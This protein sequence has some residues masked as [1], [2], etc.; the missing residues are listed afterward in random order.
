MEN[1]QNIHLVAFIDILG[2]RNI[3]G[4]YFNGKNPQALTNLTNALEQAQ[5]LGIDYARNYLT[6]KN[7][8]ISFKQ[9][10]D[11]VSI[12][13]PID[14]NSENNK[15]IYQSFI[16]VVRQYQFLLLMKGILSRGGIS[17]GK[18]IENSNMIFSEALIKAYKLE[19]ETAVYPRILVD[20]E[21][22]SSIKYLVKDVS[23][24]EYD[25]FY[26]ALGKNFLIDWDDNVFVCPFGTM[27][28]IRQFGIMLGT[29][30]FKQ[31]VNKSRQLNNLNPLTDKEIDEILASDM[32]LPVINGILKWEDNFLTK[33]SH[34]HPEILLKHKWLRQFIRWYLEPTSSQVKFG[35]YFNEKQ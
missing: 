24:Q 17:I 14:L 5:K 25:M 22:L 28:D 34:E 26:A 13:M 15:G 6:T 2:F 11:C 21:V 3:V 35:R 10:S 20:I 7:I 31:Q 16:Q 29:E 1:N 32:E 8:D 4:D 19:T 27:G 12:S 23:S 9:F 18:H 30:S 33:N